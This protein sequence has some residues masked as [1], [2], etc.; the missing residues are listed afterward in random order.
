MFGLVIL[1]LIHRKIVVKIAPWSEG[2]IENDLH[3]PEKPR[4]PHGLNLV[5]KIKIIGCLI[6][7][8]EKSMER[9]ILTALREFTS[10]SFHVRQ[11]GLKK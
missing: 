1:A 2:W 5:F 11:H 4:E 6:K 10:S 9:G 8:E 3:R 7:S